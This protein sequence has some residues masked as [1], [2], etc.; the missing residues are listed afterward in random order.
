M[1]KKKKDKII[2]YDDNSTVSDMSGVRGSRVK[3]PQGVDRTQA[4]PRAHRREE[5]KPRS[6]FKAKVK[7]YWDTVKTMFVPMLT[8]LIILAALYLVL[9]VLP[10]LF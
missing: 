8:V 1:A 2:Y 7:T 3:T 4:D 9:S 10:F 6:S 5:T